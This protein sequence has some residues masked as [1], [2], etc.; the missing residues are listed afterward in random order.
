MTRRK[1]SQRSMLTIGNNG[2]LSLNGKQVSLPMEEMSDFLLANV[3]QPCTLDDVKMKDLMNVFFHL[4]DFI[5]NYFLEEYHMINACVS[6]MHSDQKIER[7]EFGKELTIDG[8]GRVS[9]APNIN[10]KVGDDGTMSLNDA[11]VVLND[12]LLVVDH[13]NF[14][15]KSAKLWTGFTLLEVMECVFPELSHILTSG[16]GE[17][18]RTWSLQ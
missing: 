4:Q 1:I 6:T 14:M 12:R 11:V 16:S 5:R 7:V 13:S 15:V 8:E 18:G 3:S 17:S 10:V 2:K 9:M